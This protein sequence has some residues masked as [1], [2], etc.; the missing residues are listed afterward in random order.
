MKAKKIVAKRTVLM[1]IFIALVILNGLFSGSLLA[2]TKKI[3]VS[4]IDVF[5]NE[6]TKSFAA[7]YTVFNHSETDQEL[8]SIIV[9]KSTKVKWWRGALLPK[10]ESKSSQKFSL[11]FPAYIMLKNDYESIYIN[12]YT[13]NY[14]KFIDKSS[15]VQHISSKVAIAKNVN[16]LLNVTDKKI[17]TKYQS[18]KPK[19]SRIILGEKSELRSLLRS[20]VGAS[21][22][23]TKI[24]EDDA[25]VQ[26]EEVVAEFKVDNKGKAEQDEELQ[27]LEDQLLAEAEEGE[28]VEPE[29]QEL[30][31]FLGDDQLATT[32]A[33]SSLELD[34]DG[35]DINQ[36]NNKLGGLDAEI[37]EEVQLLMEKVSVDATDISSREKLV[38]LYIEN[39]QS[40]KAINFLSEQLKNN[41]EDLNAYLNLSKVYQKEGDS[42]KALEVLNYS[43]ERLSVE[44][45]I[46]VTEELRSKVEKGD[47]EVTN[48]SDAAYLANE[49]EKLGIKYIKE[50]KYQQALT[51]FTSLRG[52]LPDF[53]KVHY[54]VGISHVGLA[55]H[56]E[57]V[58][59]FWEQDSQVS[60]LFENLEGLTA[61]L[62]NTDDMPSTEKTISKFEVLKENPQ[63]PEHLSAIDKNLDILYASLKKL[64]ALEASDFAKAEAAELQDW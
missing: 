11:S 47:T 6:D 30:F 34:S 58:A 59:S 26:Q 44:S 27:Q 25:G 16:V 35:S 19:R 62:P 64:K 57:A 46:A 10:I 14:T 24:T 50:E 20:A 53:Y 55:Q 63:S 7:S 28:L 18:Q 15:R 39:K 38:S 61:A 48:L 33:E 42:N 5:W 51:T 21:A 8:S 49:Y 9:F 52:F 12:L 32:D 37:E 22:T 13:A 23:L 40:N 45:R 1:I 4:P 54:Y 36:E 60:D 41:P 3:Q 31:E 56:Y 29:D 43:L 17:K 2:Q